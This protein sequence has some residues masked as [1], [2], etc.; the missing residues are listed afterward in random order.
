M[1]KTKKL[2]FR[3]ILLTM[4]IVLSIFEAS[5]PPMPFLPPG[6][7]IGLANVVAMYALFFIGKSTAYALSVAK[8]VFVFI[9]RGVVA[10]FLSICGGMLSITIIVL[11]VIIFKNKLSYVAISI[12]GAV[13]H[14]IGQIIAC[15]FI[16]ESSYIFYYIPFLILS[17]VI[18]GTV[19]GIALK[20]IMPALDKLGLI[21]NDK[22]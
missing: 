9:S 4:I 19:T 20:S 6:V 15:F 10:G 16:L 5:L 1:K 17:G 18:M 22:R 12:F 14:N 7:K 2:T 8:S 3:A 13:F 11:I 21:L